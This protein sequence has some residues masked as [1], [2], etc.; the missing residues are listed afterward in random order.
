MSSLDFFSYDFVQ[1]L[2][3]TQLFSKDEKQTF[4]QHQPCSS[5]LGLFRSHSYSSKHVPPRDYLR[6]GSTLKGHPILS[7]KL[8]HWNLE[9]YLLVYRV[10]SFSHV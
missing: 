7:P 2:K 3:I 10:W 8:G 4:S 6:N 9:H 1:I 5:L